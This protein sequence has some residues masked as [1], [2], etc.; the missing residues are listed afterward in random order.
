MVFI[1][2]VWD[3]YPNLNL[4]II[5]VHLY[6]VWYSSK[7][8]SHTHIFTPNLNGETCRPQH[9]RDRI[10]E[11]REWTNKEK[12]RLDFKR[13]KSKWREK[14]RHGRSTCVA[15]SLLGPT[16]MMFYWI[17]LNSFARMGVMTPIGVSSIG[18]N[19][20]W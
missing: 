11:E 1:L 9:D 16:A 6:F 20:V 15:C 4:T 3:I 17:V 8:R 13:E 12:D 19:K 18:S 10:N 5:L 14:L 2:L 7:G